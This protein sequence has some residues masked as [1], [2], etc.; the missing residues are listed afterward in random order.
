MAEG[1]SSAPG[2]GTQPLR[3]LTVAG[4]EAHPTASGQML[5]KQS[6]GLVWVS[7]WKAGGEKTRLDAAVPVEMQVRRVS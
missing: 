4:T 1:R 3:S 6:V 5:L 7:E 2:V